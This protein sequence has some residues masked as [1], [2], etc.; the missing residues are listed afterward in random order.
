MTVSWEVYSPRP[1]RSLQLVA[2]DTVEYAHKYQNRD[3][4]NRLHARRG[5]CN[6]VLIVKK[7]LL[8]DTS[9]ANIALYDGQT[10]HTPKV[11][12]LP[13]TQRALLLDSGK[14]VPSNIS[15]EDLENFSSIRLFN[16][17]VPW[18]ESIH[19]PID[20]LVKP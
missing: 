15:V 18:E 19:L 7:G 20:C 16:A 12:L 5:N 6:D 2:D 17:M 1:L 9:Y 3:E 11:P 14:V 10:W 4:L 13:G 8:T